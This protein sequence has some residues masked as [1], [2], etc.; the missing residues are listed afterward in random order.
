MSIQSISSSGAAMPLPA[1]PQ[2]SVPQPVTPPQLPAVTAQSP[3]SQPQ[4]PVA[5]RAQV[6]E[7]VAKV[8]RQVQQVSINSLDFAVD[9]STGKVLVRITDRATGELIRQ[10]PSEEL[11]DIA[12]SLD[13]LQGLLLR[14]EA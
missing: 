3:S 8:K 12:Q 4:Q 6:E 11:L 13:R 10:I 2:G 5:D 7:A 9:D 1:A 14:Q